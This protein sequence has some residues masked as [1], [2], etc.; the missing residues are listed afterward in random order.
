MGVWLRL[1]LQRLL[2]RILGLLAF[3]AMFLAAAATARL[4][5]AHDGHVEFDRLMGIG[6]YPLV[7]ALLLTGWLVG[8][9]PLV[10]ALVLTAGVFSR[11]RDSGFARLLAARARTP[12]LLFALR[13]ALA[14]LL[15]VALSAV[16]LPAFDVLMLGRLPGTQ[17]FALV[18]GYVLVFGSL[19]ALLSTLTRADAWIALFA[20]IAG[21]V[22]HALLRAGAVVAAAPG[23]RG[24]LTALLPPQ[25]ALAQLENAFGMDEAVPGFALLYCALY[26]ALALVLAGVAAARRDL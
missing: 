17:L 22:W 26:A 12:L 5:A 21:I 16:V 3:G 13:I 25:G 14:L 4:F 9:F 10:A 20:A 2:P 23:P 11:D 19:T 7:S 6:G 15:A 24:L 18:L 8:R 1:E